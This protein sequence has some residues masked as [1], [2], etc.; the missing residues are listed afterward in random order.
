MSQ[1]NSLPQFKTPLETNGV[2]GKDWYF[3]WAG[4]Y[5]GLPPGLPAPITV[6]PS[7]FTFSAPIKG[8]V[9]ISGGTVSAVQFTRDGTNIYSTGATAGPFLVNQ[10]DRLIVTYTVIP[11]MVF[12]P[13]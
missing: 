2:T 3:F 1:L 13:A 9:L 8:Q 10:S 6:N 11:T 4:L 12:V 7:P 5:Q